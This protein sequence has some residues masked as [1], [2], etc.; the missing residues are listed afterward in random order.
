MIN[1][2]DKVI[3]TIRSCNSNGGTSTPKYDINTDK[4]K[5]F[6]QMIDDLDRQ[7]IVINKLIEHIFKEEW[8]IK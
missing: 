6:K 3:G 8:E 4:F 1:E 5:E 7:E 2:Y